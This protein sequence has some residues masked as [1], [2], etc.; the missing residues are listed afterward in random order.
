MQEQVE[1]TISEAICKVK[2]IDQA[3]DA[4]TRFESLDVSSLEMVTIVFEIEDAFGLNLVDSGQDHFETIG[5]A[6]DVVVR[7]LE[8]EQLTPAMA[9]SS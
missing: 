2:K 7:L 9:A 1:R 6:R 3:L 4:E 8:E 5:E